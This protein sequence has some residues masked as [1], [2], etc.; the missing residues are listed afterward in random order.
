M[1]EKLA[2]LAPTI[3]WGLGQGKRHQLRPDLGDNITNLRPQRLRK[4]NLDTAPRASVPDIAV[5]YLD[6]EH[7]LETERLRAQLKVSSG[8][9]PNAGLVLD[10]MYILALHFDHICLAR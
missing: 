5:P 6:V 1:I 7:L 9:V 10:G 3:V 2:L 4:V 8:S